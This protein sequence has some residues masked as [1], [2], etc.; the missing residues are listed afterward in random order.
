MAKKVTGKLK[1]Q[2]VLDDF[3]AA[4]DWQDECDV[5]LE[6]KKVALQ[7]RIDVTPEQEGRLIIEASDKTDIVDVY[8]YYDLRCKEAKLEQMAIL[9]NSIHVRWALGR[10]EVFP[11]GYMRWRHRVDFAGSQ[12][13]GLS[14]EN[15]VQAGW[16]AS[17]EFADPIAAVALTSLSAEEALQDY[18]QEKNSGRE[19]DSSSETGAPKEL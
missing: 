11:D 9:L 15:I 14:L 16:A 3:L 1:Y 7:T 19:E 4:R 12:P 6:E 17:S 18:D 8:F 5:N 13:T 2:I 10:F